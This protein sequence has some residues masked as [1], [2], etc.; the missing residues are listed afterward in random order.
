M[1]KALQ[2]RK[3]LTEAEVSQLLKAI[4]FSSNK[5]RHRDRTLVLLLYRHGLRRLEASQ[6]KWNDIDLVGST[7]YINRVKGSISG[8]HPLQGD[9]LRS[10]RKLKRETDPYPWVFLS[11]KN[12]PIS[13]RRITAIV[14]DYATA[15][16][17]EFRV[18]SKALRHACGYYLANKGIDTR[19]IQSYLGHAKINNTVIYTQIAAN[20]FDKLFQ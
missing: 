7:I 9:E 11:Q 19:T 14:Q 20:R 8:S 17:F 12:Q 1:V 18:T 5:Y 2:K 4:A 6:L 3:Y 15:A 10:L 16:G 13:P